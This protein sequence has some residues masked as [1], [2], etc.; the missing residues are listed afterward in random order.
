MISKLCSFCIITLFVNKCLEHI[1]EYFIYDE[2][3]KET[4]LNLVRI[5]K[6][7]GPSTVHCHGT[8]SMTMSVV[9]FQ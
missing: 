2:M 4:I 1:F 7:I 6:Y 5:M 8:L 9:P 3:E